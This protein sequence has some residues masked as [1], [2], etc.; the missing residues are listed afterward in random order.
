VGALVPD[1]KQELLIVA[2][3]GREKETVMRLARVG[4]DNALGYLDGGFEAWKKAGMEVEM[5][6]T[7]DV[8]ELE[9]RHLANRDLSILD[10]R[11]PGEWTAGHVDGAQHFPLDFINHH[12]S[13]IDRAKTYYVHCRTGYR[14][15]IAI[16]ILKARGFEHVVNVLGT[17]EDITKSRIPVTDFVSASTVVAK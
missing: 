1:L 11:K 7:V 5:I 12:M 8:E 9:K 6:D 17:F 15:T 16:S 2:P 3:A 14:S 13:D 4:Y 10:V